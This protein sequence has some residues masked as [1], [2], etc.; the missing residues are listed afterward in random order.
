MLQLY[1]MKLLHLRHRDMQHRMQ[2]ARSCTEQVDSAVSSRHFD[3]GGD[4][5]V[6]CMLT[7]AVVS[8][9][10]IAAK[11]NQME[12][13][14]CTLNKIHGRS[15][16]LETH[17]ALWK[18]PAASQPA[19][20]VCPWRCHF[21]KEMCHAYKP[22]PDMLKLPPGDQTLMMQLRVLMLREE[23]RHV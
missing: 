13:Q 5:F 7:F 22:H 16:T 20:L 23:S 21:Q 9:E 4:A 19:V 6:V 12:E 15:A 1:C 3:L 8:M 14:H 18:S 11:K 10:E 2:A 17:R